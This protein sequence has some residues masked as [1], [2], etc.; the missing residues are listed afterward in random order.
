MQ[1]YSMTKKWW[2]LTVKKKSSHSSLETLEDSPYRTLP[3]GGR[4]FPDISR[5]SHPIGPRIF[6]V[7]PPGHADLL[8]TWLEWNR[9]FN[10]FFRP[11]QKKKSA[12]KFWKTNRPKFAILS[13]IFSKNRKKS[14]L[15]AHIHFET[16]IDHD[17]NFKRKLGSWR[18]FYQVETCPLLLKKKYRGGWNFGNDFSKSL[19]Q[20]EINILGIDF[21]ENSKKSQKFQPLVNAFLE[22]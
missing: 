8:T 19:F 20:V 14:C 1:I 13:S 2:K 10:F 21:H 6:L 7:M 15:R 4:I 3:W 18:M 16:S 12:T 17:S 22:Q 11:S 9:R 5:G